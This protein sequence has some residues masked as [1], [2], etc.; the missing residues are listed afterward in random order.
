MWHMLISAEGDKM[1]RVGG[2][3]LIREGAELRNLH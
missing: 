3:R 2:R 1:P